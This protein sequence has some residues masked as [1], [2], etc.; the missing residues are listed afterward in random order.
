MWRALPLLA[1]LAS[2]VAAQQSPASWLSGCWRQAEAGQITDEVWLA[3]A[4]GTL[5]GM[6]RTLENDSL[7]SWELMV[8][9]QGPNGLSYEA[10]PSGQSSAVFLASGVSDSA[11]AFENLTHDYPQ[12]IRYTRRGSDSLIAVISGTI[13]DRQRA[14]AFH[15]ARVAC[16]GS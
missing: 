14:I 2:P 15:Y 3:P 4:G 5:L 13:R 12:L 6:S 7:L 10:S 1:V 8:I 11:I 16:P 9:R